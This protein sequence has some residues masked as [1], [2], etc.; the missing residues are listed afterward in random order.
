MF[1]ISFKMNDASTDFVYCVNKCVG[2]LFTNCSKPLLFALD[3]STMAKYT[4][5]NV[6][7]DILSTQAAA[8]YGNRRHCCKSIN[9]TYLFE[10]ICVIE[11]MKWKN[12]SKI[13]VEK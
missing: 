1:D 8:K 5:V 6:V 12:Q 13:R 2:F 7:T 11:I 3:F 10:L 9:Q 4:S